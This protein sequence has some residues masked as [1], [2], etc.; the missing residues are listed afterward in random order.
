M[1]LSDLSLI[2]SGT[3]GTGS[4][5]DPARPPAYFFGA[6]PEPGWC[7]YYEKADLARQRGDWQQIV[8]L[9]DIALSEIALSEIA[10]GNSAKMAPKDHAELIPFIIGY[11]RNGDW[12]KAFE[13][14]KI[15]YNADEKLRRTL[16]HTWE[17]LIQPTSQDAPGY[18]P[19]QPY[20]DAIHQLLQCGS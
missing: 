11:G 3:S 1:P 6:E 4:G 15:A 19:G 8:D 12:E 17:T 14:S 20:Y 5:G 2:D 10:L 16:C 13:L 9:G 18:S 7:Y